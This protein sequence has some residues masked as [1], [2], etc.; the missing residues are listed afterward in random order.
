M[1]NAFTGV[2]K[3]RLRLHVTLLKFYV[4]VC[5]CHQSTNESFANTLYFPQPLH[6]FLLAQTF[7]CSETTPEK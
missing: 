4:K 2:E 7:I 3:T 6:S 1:H 5:V